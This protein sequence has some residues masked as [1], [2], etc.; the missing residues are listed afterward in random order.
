MHVARQQ[1]FD[2]MA[3]LIGQFFAEAYGE[4]YDT[5]GVGAWVQQTGKPW[6]FEMADVIFDSGA[7]GEFAQD[8][9]VFKR[10]APVFAR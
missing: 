5:S 8:Q 4:A 3:P 1:F 2:M 9:A 6:F 10:L 7:R